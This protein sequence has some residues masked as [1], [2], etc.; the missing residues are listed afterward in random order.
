MT[1]EAAIPDGAIP[2]THLEQLYAMRYDLDGN[3]KVDH[4]GELADTDAAGVAYAAA[5][6]GVVSGNKYTG[7]ELANNLDFSDDDHYLDK[8]TNKPKWTPN[9]QTTPTNAGWAPIGTVYRTFT[10]TF[11]GR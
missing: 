1:Q 2:I 3:G 5:F 4:A 11:D 10:G 7:Y 8:D 6:P 9:H